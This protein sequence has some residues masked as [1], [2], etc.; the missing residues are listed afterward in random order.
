MECYLHIG[1]E[2]TGTT[3][4]QDFFNSNRKQLLEQGFF[5]PQSIGKKNHNNLVL[6][7]YESYRED[8]LTLGNGLYTHRN[9][10]KFQKVIFKKLK[11]EV[12]KVK[13]K[14]IIFSSELFSS[15]L[16]TK[17]ELE[18]LRTLLYEIGITDVKVVVYLREPFATAQSLLSTFVK[19][20]NVI[21]KVPNPGN[22]YYF[23]A[24]CNHKALIKRFLS[25]FDVQTLIPKL[26]IREEL[27]NNSIINDFSTTIGLNIA[28]G[29]VVSSKKKN[30][31]LS[32]NEIFILSNINRFLPRY[33]GRT[34]NI[35]RRDFVRYLI[36][37]VNSSNY[38]A[39]S[40]LKEQYQK[41]YSASNEWV[42]EKFFPT[43]IILFSE[44]NIN[45]S[46][47]IEP[48]KIDDELND[49]LYLL[50]A[51]L[52]EERYKKNIFLLI[53]L[54][55]RYLKQFIIFLLNRNGIFIAN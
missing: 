29:M 47:S 11:D 50:I 43:R 7:C 23:E 6:L 34:P 2:K 4:L 17:I 46:E 8:S 51:N 3:S 20:G 44:Y 18:R 22:H 15:R 37:N 27:E 38:Q 49:E 10:K 52:W 19:A 39:H 16:L 42:C 28:D 9:L 30:Y 53:W 26:F 13:G 5:Y 25:V 41:Y 1:T 36:K 32:K 45:D 14:K 21:N 35:I 48:Q 40:K 33:V 54:K 24:V 31:S 55:L 12:A